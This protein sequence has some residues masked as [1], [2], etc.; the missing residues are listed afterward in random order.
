MSTLPTSQPKWPLTLPPYGTCY[1]G[2][3]SLL[4]ASDVTIQF[5][6]LYVRQ[7]SDANIGA[8]IQ[9]RLAVLDNFPPTIYV[10]YRSRIDR[11]HEGGE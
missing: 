11:L 2:Y 6:E 1:A 10:I 5:N 9:D 7:H 4:V 8:P 3:I